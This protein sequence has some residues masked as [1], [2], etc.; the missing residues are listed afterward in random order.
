M[1]N[2]G[3]LKVPICG[4]TLKD[5]VELG[6]R[7][8]LL[9]DNDARDT[10]ILNCVPMVK[11]LANS[12]TCYCCYDDIF[13]DGMLGVLQAIDKYDY[14]KNVKFTSYSYYFIHKRII[15]GI[16]RQLPVSIGEKD[17]FRSF[18]VNN[19]IKTYLEEFN[20]EPSNDEVAK[21]TGFKPSDIAYFR[22]YDVKSLSV[23]FQDYMEEND[24]CGNDNDFV[25]LFE[26][27]V[28]NAKV[29]KLISGALYLLTENEQ[30]IIKGRY[31][32]QEERVPYRVLAQEQGVSISSVIKR[33]KKALR[34]FYKHFSDSNYKF[35]DL[36]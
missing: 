26:K 35:D 2:T 10:L 28:A 3:G 22:K 11:S 32:Y 8:K 7:M 33:E 24:I 31:L 25:V 12:Y 1:K 17:F 14:K 21:L 15:D 18:V 4:L 23:S 5:Q 20:V 19:T 29:R 27:G 13:Q 16:R 36:F 34:K 6:K 30:N 9:N